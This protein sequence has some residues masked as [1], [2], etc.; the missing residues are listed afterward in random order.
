MK[1]PS[2]YAKLNQSSYTMLAN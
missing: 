1:S 2:Q